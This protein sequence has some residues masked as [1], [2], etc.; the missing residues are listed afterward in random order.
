M[1]NLF[2]IQATASRSERERL[3]HLG[4][5]QGEL[6][7]RRHPRQEVAVTDPLLDLDERV[8]R[9]ERMAQRRVFRFVAGGV[10]GVDRSGE[11]LERRWR[12]DGGGV[13]L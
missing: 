13:R 12:R 5:T 4:E 9:P 7:V 3:V 10:G 6:A 11:T 1:R 8:A 2:R